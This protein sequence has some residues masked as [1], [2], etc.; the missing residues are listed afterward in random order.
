[1]IEV[2][3]PIDRDLIIKGYKK[4]YAMQVLQNGAAF[5]SWRAFIVFL[6]IAIVDV[7]YKSGNLIGIH[8]YVITGLAFV[9]SLYHYFDWLKQVST[10]ARDSELHVVL[11]DDGVILKDE[12]D[13]RIEWSSYKYFKEYEDYLEITNSSGEISFLPKNNDLANVIIFTKSKIPNYEN[14]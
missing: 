2:H 13:R 12:A 9:A 11:D 5:Y 1:M 4:A 6:V 14:N 7:I 10:N 8:L 3:I